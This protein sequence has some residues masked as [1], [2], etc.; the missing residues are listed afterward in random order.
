M[1]L[2]GMSY[3]LRVRGYMLFPYFLPLTQ[4]LRHHL[5]ITKFVFGV[6]ISKVSYM[7]WIVLS[8]FVPMYH[9]Y[10]GMHIS[11]PN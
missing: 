9:P 11:Q 4:N 7:S 1:D 2:Q 5:H 3:E 6:K 8:H 10:G